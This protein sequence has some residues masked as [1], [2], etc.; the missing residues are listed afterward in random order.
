MDLRNLLANFNLGIVIVHRQAPS[1]AQPSIRTSHRQ[2]QPQGLLVDVICCGLINPMKL[3]S[4][5]TIDVA[6]TNMVT[7]CEKPS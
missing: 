6:N 7:A 4:I 5:E 3:L 2:M 1:Y